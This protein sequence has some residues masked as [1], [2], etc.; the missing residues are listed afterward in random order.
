MLAVY[1]V[2]GAFLF[3]TIFTVLYDYSTH[4]RGSEGPTIPVLGQNI[5]TPTENVPVQMPYGDS[6]IFY[7]FSER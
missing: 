3:L 2:L 7:G 4:I 1:A 6:T 5:A